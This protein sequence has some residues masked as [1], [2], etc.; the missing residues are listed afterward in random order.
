M[1][2]MRDEYHYL[3]GTLG[4]RELK[5]EQYSPSGVRI[6]GLELSSSTKL[7]VKAPSSAQS[8]N[9]PKQQQWQQ[10]QSQVE[11]ILS[12]ESNS[13]SAQVCSAQFMKVS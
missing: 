5:L 4:F 12:T 7:N 8:T 6:T 1:G 11:S 2:M 3:V 13:A 9:Y 10:H